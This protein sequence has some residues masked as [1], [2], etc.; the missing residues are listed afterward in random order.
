MRIAD[1]LAGVV[2]LSTPAGTLLDVIARDGKGG[3]RRVRIRQDL[4]EAALRL[5]VE[6]EEHKCPTLDQLVD[7][8]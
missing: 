7:A 2:A 6:Q 1:A 8:L 5:A 4:L 3:A